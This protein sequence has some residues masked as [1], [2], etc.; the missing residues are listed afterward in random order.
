M[1]IWKKCSRVISYPNAHPD[2][3]MYRCLP[4]LFTFIALCC[5]TY[6]LEWK[7]VKKNIWLEI[8]HLSTKCYF[9]GLNC[10]LSTYIKFPSRRHYIILSSLFTSHE[11]WGCYKSYLENIFVFCLSNLVSLHHIMKHVS[12][13]SSNIIYPRHPTSLRAFSQSAGERSCRCRQFCLGLR[14]PQVSSIPPPPDQSSR[15]EI[16]EALKKG[17]FLGIIPKPVDTPPSLGTFRKKMSL[18]GHVKSDGPKI[19]HKN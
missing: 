3:V 8:T 2:R 14:C 11:R 15:P 10:A 13:Y 12:H 9:S 7:I 17:Y 6:Q 1:K 16:T 18:L 19:S 5:Y 4:E